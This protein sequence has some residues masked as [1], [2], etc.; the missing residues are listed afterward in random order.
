MRGERTPHGE[1]ASRRGGPE[2]AGLEIAP[3]TIEI[4]GK[5]DEPD[6][7]VEAVTKALGETGRAA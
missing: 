7:I 2:F 4:V 6:M 5:P 1:T 3:D